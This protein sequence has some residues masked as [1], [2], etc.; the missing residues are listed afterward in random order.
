[1]T[2]SRARD[3][4]RVT[5]FPLPPVFY[6]FFFLPDFP[7]LG[8]EVH[9]S[10]TASRPPNLSLSSNGWRCGKVTGGW[11]VRWKFIFL[12]SSLSY[13]IYVSCSI[14]ILIFFLVTDIARIVP[15]FGRHIFILW[16]ACVSVLF[17][18]YI[19][20]WMFR[21]VWTSLIFSSS[22]RTMTKISNPRFV[23]FLE[24][25]MIDDFWAKKITDLRRSEELLSF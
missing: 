10:A 6:S 23:G 19:P 2:L 9:H 5:L 13:C 8:C 24:V 16:I 3:P 25:K 15:F 18:L 20:D 1:M 21:I 17:N 4:D 14:L 12:L 7:C 11:T 22:D